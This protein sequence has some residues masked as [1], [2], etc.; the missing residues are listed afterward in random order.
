MLLKLPFELSNRDNCYEQSYQHLSGGDDV[1][2]LFQMVISV[3]HIQI[4]QR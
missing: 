3:S 2:R 1:E 4:L